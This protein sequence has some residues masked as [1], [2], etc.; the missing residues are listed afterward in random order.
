MI[1]PLYLIFS[2]NY[3]HFIKKKKKTEKIEVNKLSIIIIIIIMK[4]R[5]YRRLYYDKRIMIK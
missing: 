3:I 1:I 2:S 5:L 4:A